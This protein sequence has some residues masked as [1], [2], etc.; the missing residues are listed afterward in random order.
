[1]M[2]VLFKF[3][4]FE[5]ILQSTV[6]VFIFHYFNNTRALIQEERELKRKQDEDFRLSVSISKVKKYKLITYLCSYFLR[7]ISKE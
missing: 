2:F 7:F 3:E 4:Y 5:F 1:M 6:R